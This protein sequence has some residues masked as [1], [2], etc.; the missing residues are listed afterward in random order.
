MIELQRSLN[1]FRDHG[2]VF[3]FFVI[4]CLIVHRVGEE[5]FSPPPLSEPY[6]TVSRHPAQALQSIP[7]SR[8]AVRLPMQTNLYITDQHSSPVSGGQRQLVLRSPSFAFPPEEDSP[9][10]HVKERRHGTWDPFRVR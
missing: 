6:L 9:D 8:V 2:C 7:P 10:F 1:I 5:T 3:I 4:L